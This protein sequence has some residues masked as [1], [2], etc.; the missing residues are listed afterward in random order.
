[1]EEEKKDKKPDVDYVKLIRSNEKKKSIIVIL[2]FLIIMMAAVIALFY[3]GIVNMPGAKKCNDDTTTQTTCTE[4]P[5]CEDNTKE[6]NCPATTTNLGEKIS[7]V[8]K[9][10]LTDKNQTIKVGKESI[11]VRVGTGDNYGY[12]A[13]DDYFVKSNFSTDEVYVDNAYVTDKF[14]FFTHN[15]QAGEMISYAY[16]PY[17]EIITNNNGYQIDDAS[18]KIVNGYL[19]AMGA[20][21]CGVDGPDENASKEEKEKCKDHDLLIKYIDNT[22]IVVDAK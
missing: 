6:C 8:K 7:S 15:A 2:I 1:M 22:L 14:I 11:K 9:I 16:V 20:P 4:C 12:L 13:I 18:F 10:T 5:K 21:F 19:H 3:F 17:G